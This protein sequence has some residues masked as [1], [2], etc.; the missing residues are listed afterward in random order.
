LQEFRHEEEHGFL[1]IQLQH[2]RISALIRSESEKY[3]FKDKGDSKPPKP[4]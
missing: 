4:R 1:Q 2:G 3:P